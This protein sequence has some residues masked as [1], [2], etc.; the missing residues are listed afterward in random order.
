MSGPVSKHLWTSE[1]L[2]HLPDDGLK[3]E[4]QAGILVS[5][6][7]PGTRHG[8][9]T[10]H[11]GALLDAH[12]RRLRLGVVLD[13]SEFVL[14]RSP[15]T[16]RGPDL[17]FITRRRFE[18]LR[19]RTKAFPG[20][21]D[22]ALEVLSPTNTPASV[23]AKVADYR[24]AGNRAGLLE[25][26]DLAEGQPS[27]E[28]TTIGGDAGCAIRVKVARAGLASA[29]HLKGATMRT[30][31][32]PFIFFVLLTFVLGAVRVHAQEFLWA[33]RMG[34]A[35]IDSGFGIAAD[36][37]GNV[38]TTGVFRGLVDFDPGPGLY[39]LASVSVTSD[40]FV[41]KLD[42]SGNF[43]WARQLGGGAEDTGNS[44]AVDGGGNVYT[45]GHFQG[46]AD[47][48]PGP[49]VFN[50]TSA[51]GYDIFVSKLDANGNFV[52]AKRIGASGYDEAFSIAVDG[53]E[54]VYTT[55]VFASITDFDPGPGVSNLTAAGRDMFV[56]KLDANGD[57]L[58]ARQVGAEAVGR[59]IAVDSSGNVY[60]TGVLS[61]DQVGNYILISKL[62]STG[63]FAWTRQLG[64][65][66]DN[67]GLSIAVDSSG[68]AY[69][70][71]QFTGVVDFDPGVG[72]Y[73]LVSAASY[74]IFVCKLD[75]NGNFVWAKQ[76]G[77]SRWGRG[78]SIAVDNSGNV[79]TT[80]EFTGTA[81][82]D[83]GPG[84][85]DL[86]SVRESDIFISK[87]DTNGNFVWAGGIGG[88]WFDYGRSIAVDRS[89]NLLTTGSFS[90]TADFDPGTGVYN[91]TPDALAD[92]FVCKLSCS[93]L[94]TY[95]RD[96]DD[97][98][99]GDPAVSTNS[100]TCSRPAGYVTNNS[101][102]N[103]ADPTI[104]PGASDANC[105][106]VDE[107]CS[108][109][110]DDGFVP[111]TT[112]CGVGACARTGTTSCAGGQISDNCVPGS[113][114][115]SADA[116]C[117]GV[118][119]DCDGST[120]E[121]FVSTTTQCGVG[122]CARSGATS[123]VEGHLQNSCTPGQPSPEACNGL[124]D[125]CDGLS[126]DGNP[127]GGG[128]CSTGLPGVCGLG[129]IACVGGGLR[130]QQDQ[131]AGAEVCDGLDDDC[132]GLIDEGNP[133]GGGACGTA[134][135]GVCAQ[136]MTT[137]VGGAT[138]CRR[139]RGPGPEVCNGLDDNCNGQ[140]DEAGDRDGDGVGD[141]PDHCPDAYDPG[142]ADA[143]GD[144]IGDACDCAPGDPLNG[145]PP[146]VHGVR[147]AQVNGTADISWTGEGFP[148][149][150]QV[151]RGWKNSGQPFQRNE[152][153]MG[154]PTTSTSAEDPRMPGRGVLFYYLV[155]R[156][157]GCAR[158]CPGGPDSDG[159]GICDP[160]DN[161]SVVHN[162]SQADFDGDGGGDACDN[163]A[164]IANPTQ[165]DRDGDGIGDARDTGCW[166]D[167]DC[168]DGDTCTADA[169]DVATGICSHAPFACF[170]GLR[171]GLR[172]ACKLDETSGSVTH[173]WVS[174]TTGTL[175]GGVLNQPG[176]SAGI[177]SIRFDRN[178]NE[179]LEF[180]QAMIG[181]LVNFSTGSGSFEAW[182]KS[183]V[184]Y[185]QVVFQ[186]SV[187]GAD[188][189]YQALLVNNDTDRVI[190]V[191]VNDGTN[192]AS[193]FP[194][195]TNHADGNWHQVVLVVDRTANLLRQYMDGTEVGTASMTAV[196]SPDNSGVLSLGRRPG[197][198]DSYLDGNL[199][200]PRMW[201]RPL[202]PAEVLQ[203]YNNGSGLDITVGAMPSIK[204]GLIAGWK[205]E[206]PSG[207]LGS[208]LGSSN[209]L[210]PAV[211]LQYHQTGKVGFG[212]GFNGSSSYAQLADFGASQL[213]IAPGQKR[214]Q[215]AWI[216]L[217]G[218]NSNQWILGKRE[219]ASDVA[220]RWNWLRD[221]IGRINV[222]YFDTTTS[223]TS[224]FTPPL[225]DGSFHLVIST[226]EYGKAD[227]VKLYVDNALVTTA[228]TSGLAPI[229]NDRP[230]TL[231]KLA[232]APGGYFFDGVL[233]E[234][235]FWSRILSPAEM[236]ALWNG[237][238]GMDINASSP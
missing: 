173:D 42:A 225:A 94:V 159:D 37:I 207:S 19:D 200:L 194:P 195:A 123:C 237:G 101:D 54:S 218:P 128:S 168:N 90:A 208:T 72:V 36:T 5:E 236:D 51:G 126:D 65:A 205:M 146:E 182:F 198:N 93:A 104:H 196:G 119:D 137:C 20:A 224:V 122:L 43:V 180:N 226:F 209:N 231:G 157:G 6:P 238:A 169:C 59:S 118:D 211:N 27:A 50:L 151:Y 204:D 66:G 7:L 32:R 55:G 113:P 83:P 213:N 17:A 88:V 117:D 74:D 120:D 153:P 76:Q 193:F 158:A 149:P 171:V 106:G 57:F 67:E 181:A 45:V 16:V 98:L 183:S 154:A 92:V 235:L 230:F 110:P 170:A 131:P 58:W 18:E 105:N 10:L 176:P 234:V 160:S 31:V 227:G 78:N 75:L 220:P 150:F 186:K 15:D 97:D 191:A 63:S 175:T 22:L 102:C 116:T 41:S 189:R 142:Q 111:S 212:V 62:D 223:G 125:D 167:A 33:K 49:G 203:L 202:S 134:Q 192:S 68:N 144:G 132:N 222:Q 155:T 12:V 86:T 80:G 35:G 163:C 162:P 48:D 56:S 197:F 87:L 112:Q 9:V 71:G 96:V 28:A 2:Y 124:D 77:V 161:C 140:V 143:D 13:H 46:T 8:H 99:Y 114:I 138:V 61:V 21:P 53:A 178:L 145:S 81:D 108:G 107:D 179:Y 185:P 1:D 152:E 52:W 70:T 4:L 40:A 91:L 30:I 219:Q 115:S 14:S 133:G 26:P 164:T 82:F 73:A 184:N 228:S 188:A 172:W 229:V 165:A 177:P 215:A 47:F 121:N 199:A 217:L 210:L 25:S 11:L 127:G 38:Y 201:N 34:E 130:C 190:Q 23:H 60:A 69:A 79:Y 24:A 147:V 84:T 166:L 232:F 29:K 214:T 135:P 206:E 103:D 141:C 156:V 174:N 187:T 129:T 64:G 95:Y 39:I 85:Y 100:Y 109:T 89:G 233:D 3:H 148:G 216:K 44:I 221:S 136:G 139:Q